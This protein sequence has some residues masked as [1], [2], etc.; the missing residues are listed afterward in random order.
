MLGRPDRNHA[1][2]DTCRSPLDKEI[3][4]LAAA[5]GEYHF[6]R[7][8]VDRCCDPLPCLVDRP[9][10]RTAVVVATGGVAEAAFQ[11]RQHGRQ[12]RRIKRRRGVV[13]EIDGIEHGA[14]QITA[15]TFSR[16]DRDRGCGPARRS[17]I[18]DTTPAFASFSRWRTTRSAS[19]TDA[20]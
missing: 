7:M 18:T 13:V 5:A 4:G 20:R 12:H 3:V 2:P 11:P 9:P 1:R 10:R 19:V 15:A 16:T 8:R 17:A 14:A 6:G